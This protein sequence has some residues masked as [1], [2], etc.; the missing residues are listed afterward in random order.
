MADISRDEHHKMTEDL[1][2]VVSWLPLPVYSNIYWIYN[3]S[4]FRKSFIFSTEMNEITVCYWLQF[5][6]CNGLV[7]SPEN[8]L[9]TNAYLPHLRTGWEG[10]DHAHR[11]QVNQEQSCD[12]GRVV[13]LEDLGMRTGQGRAGDGLLGDMAC[14]QL[15][16]QDIPWVSVRGPCRSLLQNRSQSS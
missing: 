9:K 16:W 11:H 13:V 10:A 7:N 12:G 5:V 14:W 2:K 4:V 8:W 6:M 1:Q 3:I 15:G